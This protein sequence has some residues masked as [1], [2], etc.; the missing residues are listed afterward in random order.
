ML[1]CR[2]EVRA[3]DPNRPGGWLI[4]ILPFLSETPAQRSPRG[5]EQRRLVGRRPA[6]RAGRSLGY[7]RFPSCHSERS[8]GISDYYLDAMQPNR[9]R[10][11]GFA[12]HDEMA[13]I[14]KASRR[15]FSIARFLESIPNRHA[16]VFRL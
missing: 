15:G 13:I 8:R 6:E 14:L 11:L 4:A 1:L 2:P 9:K 16:D 12:R 7:Q 5:I 3:I 10:C